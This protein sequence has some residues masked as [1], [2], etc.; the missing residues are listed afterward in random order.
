MTFIIRQ[1]SFFDK[2]DTHKEIETKNE[3]GE[4]VKQRVVGHDGKI[5]AMEFK[6]ALDKFYSLEKTKLNDDLYN[7]WINN[8][9]LSEP[10]TD[11]KTLLQKL[12]DA[13]MNLKGYFNVQKNLSSF[14]ASEGQ[15]TE[16]KTFDKSKIPQ[17]PMMDY[18]RILK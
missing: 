14:S 5:D 18:K 2:L 8:N 12:S 16:I 11:E 6:N 1:E 4:K 10:I 15:P 7:Q 9:T 3:K 17:S 13:L